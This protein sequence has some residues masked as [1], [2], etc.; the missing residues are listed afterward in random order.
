MSMYI[1]KK[2][3]KKEMLKK[4]SPGRKNDRRIKAL[5][6]LEETKRSGRTLIHGTLLDK[7]GIK[8]VDTEIKILGSKIVAVEAARGIRSKKDRSDTGRRKGD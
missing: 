6:R 2:K 8:R 7:D 4:N 3:G 5:A 1:K